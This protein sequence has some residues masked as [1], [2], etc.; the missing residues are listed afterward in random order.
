MKVLRMVSLFGLVV[1]FA[2]AGLCPDDASA[3]SDRHV[4]EA[5]KILDAGRPLLAKEKLNEAL[6]MD[7]ENYHAL[8]LRGQIEMQDVTS[9]NRGARVL[10]AE[11]CFLR[12][13]VAQPQRPEAYLGLAQLNYSLGYVKEGDKYARMARSLDPHSYKALCLV[14][15]RYE[16]SGNFTGALDIYNLALT[17]YPFDTYLL[18]KRYV[19]AAS[20]G[21]EPEEVYILEAGDGKNRWRLTLPAYPDFFL[22]E[23][24]K[25]ESVTDLEVTPQYSLPRFTLS[26]CEEDA[27]PRK[28]F[29][30]LFGPFL[31]A[32]LTDE[33][34]YRRLRDD[35]QDIRAKA[36]D[37]IAKAQGD[38]AK[39]KA[40]YDWLK[41]DVLG[42]YDLDKGMLAADILRDKNYV[43]LNASILYT[44]LAR[45]NNLP[46]NGVLQARHA[47]AI[48]EDPEK[49]VNI[50]LSAE[51]RFGMKRA[52]GFGADWWRQFQ[53]KANMEITGGLAADPVDRNIG[54]V[55]PDTLTAYQFLNAKTYGARR[56]EE[57]FKEEAELKRTL[58]DKIM[59]LNREA[60]S[61]IAGLESRY[62]REPE[63]LDTL[64][65]L[66][67]E[68]FR[69][70]AEQL[71]RQA[72]SIG[73]K[74]KGE[75]A[76]FN[77]EAGRRLMENARS[78]APN[79][80]EFITEIERSYSD[81]ALAKLHPVIATMNQ[82]ER[83]IAEL[84]RKI[85][86]VFTERAVEERFSGP[87][88]TFVDELGAKLKGL[89]GRVDAVKASRKAEWESKERDAWLNA[90]NILAA[91]IKDFP[92]S[93]RLKRQLESYCWQA[94]RI[95]EDNEDP[96]TRDKI[97]ELA[98]EY[99]PG[100]DF[101]RRYR[102][103]LSGRF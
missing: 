23:E 21:L 99:L 8:V 86:K 26:Y 2:A 89:M 32:G 93:D 75:L 39:A 16:D 50:E 4:S 80:E 72:E 71:Q 64:V 76:R 30:D 36:K 28:R 44:L 100:S 55:E 37:V 13:C 88:S 33:S 95:A 38:K 82:R 12:G 10:F 1:C 35:L 63:K 67:R 25:K 49:P 69:D 61:Q 11:S 62:Q 84:R 90:M 68:K 17:H 101:T 94:A 66:T 92:C 31:Q 34:S 78:L 73:F 91:G 5:L 70:E 85:A 48:L 96:M 79:V 53:L 27:P 20:G 40:L 3:R 15:Q 41:T 7:P 77:Y 18:D 29:G 45:E 81:M 52:E 57:R 58:E 42:K 60:V 47:Y 46:V 24:F 65:Q 59:D 103:K 51:P 56:I 22:L 102:Q 54:V 6:Q 83:Q 98:S 87:E 74:I 97:L 19:A 14:G 9:P 43:S